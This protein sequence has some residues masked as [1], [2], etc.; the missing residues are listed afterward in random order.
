MKFYGL[1]GSDIK[2]LCETSKLWRK[3]YILSYSLFDSA[4]NSMS[5]VGEFVPVSASPNSPLPVYAYNS[6]ITRLIKFYPS[7]RDCVKDLE[8]NKNFNTAS[9]VLRI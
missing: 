5:T 2:L 7:M 3:A 6:D 9:L 4:D 1:N 8:G